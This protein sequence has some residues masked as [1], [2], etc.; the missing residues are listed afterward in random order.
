[1]ATAILLRRRLAMGD[2]GTF[3]GFGYCFGGLCCIIVTPLFFLILALY[4]GF[5]LSVDK[6]LIII[7]ISI[8]L[9]FMI[10]DILRLFEHTKRLSTITILLGFS[11]GL[12]HIFALTFGL[13]MLLQNLAMCFV[14]PVLAS[15][16]VVLSYIIVFGIFIRLNLR[17][18]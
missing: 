2:R 15:I 8:I 14:N 13:F 17:L 9:S 16:L 12:F 1:M 3:S 11:T 7:G 5:I 4:K 6:C 18:P 10:P